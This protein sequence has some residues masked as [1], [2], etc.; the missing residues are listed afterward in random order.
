MYLNNC[1]RSRYY[2]DCAFLDLS[3]A[4][5]KEG[6]NGRASERTSKFKKRAD[7]KRHFLTRL[8]QEKADLY[9]YFP[10][11]SLSPDLVLILIKSAYFLYQLVLAKKESR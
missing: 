3:L 11:I 2:L 5:L 4:S 10:P 8:R 9:K 7:F 1:A 6:A